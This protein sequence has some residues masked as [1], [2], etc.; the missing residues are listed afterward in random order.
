M[1]S[2][3]L[4]ALNSGVPRRSKWS[5]IETV[6]ANVDRQK[7]RQFVPSGPVRTAILPPVARRLKISWR[8]E[9]GAKARAAYPRHPPPPRRTRPTTSRR[10]RPST[11]S[12]RLRA[13]CSCSSS[14]T[15]PSRYWS[16]APAVVIDKT[17][18]SAFAEPRLLS[19]LRRRGADA[20]VVTGSET[21]VC[22]MG[23][24]M[25]AVDLGFRVILVRD[26]VCSSSDEGPAL[27]G[28]RIHTTSR[29]TP[30]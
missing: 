28:G 12:A 8:G 26:A 5:G 24:V 15:A 29:D 1:G 3:P 14:P 20:L 16:R 11:K 30:S 19:H 18:Y 27:A 13:C 22:V 21:D 23:T 6:A 17:R 4:L 10:P 7:A 2:C 25:G 9:P